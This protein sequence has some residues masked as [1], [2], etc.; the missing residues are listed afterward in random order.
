[1]SAAWRLDGS[2]LCI[3]LEVPEGT[4][5]QMD[6]PKGKALTVD[7]RDAATLDA[8]GPGR[9]EISIRG[10][11]LAPC[12]GAIDVEE[13]SSAIRFAASSSH[14]APPSWSISNLSKARRGAKGWS[15]KPHPSPDAVE[16]LEL[17]FGSVKSVERLDLY[18]RDDP[19]S[20]G[21]RAGFPCAFTIEGCDDAGE[22]RELK[23]FGNAEPPAP[24]KAFSVD[25][26]TVIDYPKVRRLRIKASKLGSPAADEP[27][28]WRM[29]FKR[30]EAALR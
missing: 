30:V 18:P 6:L 19:A 3:E 17:D 12:V 20:L 14:E 7:G 26:Y 15:S 5:A 21:G 25:F 2:D 27:G 28:T 9:H 16:W 1:V 29:Q 23:A 11:D 8:L 22:W 10:V 24:G 13:S 4:L